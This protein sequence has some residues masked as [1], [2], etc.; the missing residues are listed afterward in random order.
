MSDK[1]KIEWLKGGASWNPIVAY[2]GAGL[3]PAPTSDTNSRLLLCRGGFG[4]FPAHIHIEED[5][6]PG[7]VDP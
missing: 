6:L 5:P 1:S 2:V 3:K 7:L 4:H